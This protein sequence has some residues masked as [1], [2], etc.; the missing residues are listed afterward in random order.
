MRSTILRP[1]CRLL[2][3]IAVLAFLIASTVLYSFKSGLPE[4]S[5][6]AALTDF[7][8]EP[9]NPRSYLSPMTNTSF[10][11]GVGGELEYDVLLDG[12]SHSIYS[13]GRM[14]PETL[15]KWHIANG[16][17]AVVVSD[18][19]TIAGGL[20]AQEIALEK[21]KDNI[22]VIPA[23]ELTCCR[24]HMNLIGINETI[25][26]AIRKWPTDEQIKAT[27]D[28]THALGGLAIINH[29]PWSNTT[30]YGY[31]LPRMQN[32]PSRE[33]LVEMGI[34]GF[35]I[36]NGGTLDTISLKFIQDNN[37]LLITG[38]DVHYPETGAYSWTILNT[39]NNRSMANIMTQLR[40]RNTSFLFDPTGT[41]QI[42]YPPRNER[43]YKSA[44][45]RLLGQYFQMFWTT[46]TGMYS[47]SPEGG[48][49][50]EEQLSILWHLI[51]YF[52]TWVLLGFL[53]FE[54][55]R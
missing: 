28:R 41:Q 14:D 21:Y 7:D 29:I 39:N 25:D 47:F 18:H 17:N 27:I 1:I 33:K 55:A 40:V 10:G 35:E 3:L 53:I 44:P 38:T 37:L 32:H 9:I 50:H 24:L 26:I 52:F 12:H 49:C 45:P 23:M 46:Q 5:D 22:T 11:V 36:V 19:N 30:E 2:I 43:Y 16:Y 20:A 54:A 8:W 6:Y 42:A 51:G 48:F 31:H 34:D 13:D 4:V 15:L